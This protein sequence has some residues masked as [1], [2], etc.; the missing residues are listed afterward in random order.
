M[1]FP[2]NRL[3]TSLNL[4]PIEPR[5]PCP[6]R[7]YSKLYEYFDRE[8]ASTGKKR[9]RPRKTPTTT[10]TRP[11][12]ERHAPSLEKGLEA[13][14]GARTPR[15]GLKHGGSA[16][17]RQLPKWASPAIR[18][19][20]AVL[21]AGRAVPHVIAGV[22]S[23]LFLPCP[24]PEDAE[25]DQIMHDAQSANAAVKGKIPALVVAILAFVI[26]K[27]SGKETDAKEYNY[28]VKTSLAVLRDMRRDEG[29]IEK[30][31]KEDEAWEGWELVTKNDVN[32]WLK[33][34]GTKGWLRMDW[35]ENM[36][37]GSGASGQVEENYSDG[38]DYE[39]HQ[40][41]AAERERE[42]EQ[43][44]RTRSGTMVQDQFDYLSKAKREQF[45]RW[46]ELML[47]KIDNLEEE[48]GQA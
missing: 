31:G 21:D 45:A 40:I 2:D 4:P 44:W 6:P 1:S 30:I 24:G 33:D 27:L 26:A 39:E 22:E 36:D 35:W 3:K 41:A 8:L 17:G 43:L 37:G 38:E 23:V 7:I 47:A 28:R 16:K 48:G 46:K 10:P 18:A 13:F 11:L 32:E 20:C 29:M 19:L 15:H 34:I 42:K 5:P 14:K 9:G 25:G 12:P